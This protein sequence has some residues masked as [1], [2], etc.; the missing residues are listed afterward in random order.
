MIRK[1]F[2]LALLCTG[3]LIADD[4]KNEEK[5]DEAFGHFIG[6]NLNNPG[7]HFD[8][9]KVIKGIRDGAAG[10][11]APLSDEEYQRLMTINQEK[12]MKALT[13][14]NL[15]KANEFL[16]KNAKEKGIVIVEPGKLQ[17]QILKEGTGEAVVETSTPQIEYTGS[18]LD[19][20]VFGSSAETGGPI[21]VPL[22]QIIPGF[23]KGVIGMKEG[24]R[25]KIFVHPELGYGE[26]GPLPPNS[27]LI[28]EVTL[29]K[30]N[31]PLEEPK[32]DSELPNW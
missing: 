14:E 9:E 26:E 16:D 18:L 24:E 17:V 28:F 1:L 21:T 23:K 8:V 12:A 31:A 13:L 22:D 4:S 30:A 11:P 25:R 27:L 15:K 2:L 19:G 3:S 5:L 29:L 6:R 32:D 7:I 10:K 20:E